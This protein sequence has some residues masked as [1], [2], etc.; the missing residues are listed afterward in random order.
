MGNPFSTMLFNTE[1]GLQF[2]PLVAAFILY[3]SQS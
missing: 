2:S 3:D 1:E